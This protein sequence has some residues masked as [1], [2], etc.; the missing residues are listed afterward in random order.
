M[1]KRNK[2]AA[3][4]GTFI[5]TVLP[6]GISSYKPDETMQETIRVATIE[7]GLA[8]PDAHDDHLVAVLENEGGPVVSVEHS[9]ADLDALMASLE[10]PED[11]PILSDDPEVIA[12][13][14]G[15]PDAPLEDPEIE[16]TEDDE[17][18]LETLVQLIAGQDP[19][20]VEFTRESA[21]L[22][23]EARDA[24]EKSKG[25]HYDS[26]MKSINKSRSKLTSSGAAAIMLAAQ[27]D[28]EFVNRSI[29]AG[30][31]YNAYAIDKV[32]DLVS[33]LQTGTI[34]NAINN[35]IIRSLFAFEAAGVAFTGEMA[36]AAAS[37]NIKVDSAVR[38]LLVSYTVSPA[39]APTQASSTM[40]ALQTL[41]VVVNLG[42]PKLPT[43][44][45]TR[46]PQT[47]SFREMLA[48]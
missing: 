3:T 27:V 37:Q 10:N 14:I 32:A 21:V 15:G 26:I 30:S 35:A 42:S 28:P 6:S 33:A 11:A 9:D 20:D 44:K 36:K 46:S 18:P 24:F 5:E 22:A 29:T 7:A 34:K 47:E 41:G 23:F 12:E 19:D 16:D 1:T 38:K 13:V 39:T 4:E 2:L 48:A 45:L 43:Y 31:G 8:P 17:E 40:A 25:G